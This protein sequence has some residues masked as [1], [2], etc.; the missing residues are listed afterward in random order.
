MLLNAIDD[1]H[2]LFPRPFPNSSSFIF[3]AKSSSPVL[4][5]AC[6]VPVGG[7]PRAVSVSQMRT[8]FSISFSRVNLSSNNMFRIS[9][10]YDFQSC[11][12]VVLIPAL[13]DCL[14]GDYPPQFGGPSWLVTILRLKRIQ[15][16][17]LQVS[18]PF[19]VEC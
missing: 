7:N 12:T 16:P 4:S 3:V 18:Q 2:L 14:P 13:K 1:Y 17:P 8:E 15:I 10:T 6:F 9:S 5:A 19:C 11:I